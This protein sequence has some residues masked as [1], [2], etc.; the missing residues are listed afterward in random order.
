MHVGDI[1]RLGQSGEGDID[2]DGAPDR[3]CRGGPC[4]KD[5]R[6]STSNGNAQSGT[7]ILNHELY[8]GRMVSS[9]L[10]GSVDAEFE[11]TR[12]E[13]RRI[14][15]QLDRL[16]NAAIDGIVSLCTDAKNPDGTSGFWQSNS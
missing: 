4:D 9:G 12:T 6:T 2:L 10:R 1:R 3:R 5:W 8:I 11:A 7:G 16:A 15:R 14:D 13:V